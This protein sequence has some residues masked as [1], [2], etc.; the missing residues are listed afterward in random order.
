MA[1]KTSGAEIKDAN[2]KTASS[3]DYSY[4]ITVPQSQ[5][6]MFIKRCKAYCVD[7]GP[8]GIEAWRNCKAFSSYAKV[9]ALATVMDGLQNP[10]GTMIVVTMQDGVKNKLL[11][12]FLG[13][14]AILYSLEILC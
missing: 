9:G 10:A 3:G 5:L 14:K 7:D 6:H 2:G 13:S 11:C 4:T 8:R 1:C 12:Y